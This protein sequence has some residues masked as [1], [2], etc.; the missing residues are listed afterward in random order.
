MV[1]KD[2]TLNDLQVFC[3]LFAGFGAFEGFEGFSFI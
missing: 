1:S 2:Y 3:V